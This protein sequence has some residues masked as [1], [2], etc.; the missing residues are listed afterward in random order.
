MRP[1]FPAP[2]PVLGILASVPVSDS[3]SVPVGQAG[4]KRVLREV[5]SEPFEDCLEPLHA[6]TWRAAPA[7][8]VALRGEPEHLHLPAHQAQQREQM[9]ALLDGTA[10]V[11]LGVDD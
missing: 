10:Q 8:L 4:S 6:M 3:P 7:Q 5:A 9:L 1:G 11:L 2:G